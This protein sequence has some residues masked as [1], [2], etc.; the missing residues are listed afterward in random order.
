MTSINE[1]AVKF[2]RVSSDSQ[3]EANQVAAVDKHFAARGYAEAREPFKLHD[4]SASKGE[5]EKELAEILADVKAGKYTVV[6]I[7]NSARIDRRDPDL[8]EFWSLSVR[9]AGGR[10]ESASEPEFGKS[11][12]SGKMVT[13]LAQQANYDYTRTLST[14]VRN[15]FNRIDA[16]GGI[17]NAAGYGHRIV[18]EKY[19]K[20]FVLDEAEADV[21]R[22]VISRYLSGQGLEHI[23]RWLTSEGHRGRNGAKW[24]PRTLG[25]LLRNERLIGRFHQGD[26]VTRVPSITTVKNYQATLARLDAKAYRK[27]ARTRDDNALLTS[28]LFC[29]KCGRPMYAIKGGGTC[30]KKVWNADKT[31]KITRRYPARMT[32]NYYCRPKGGV[33]CKMMVDLGE[34]D[35]EVIENFGEEIVVAHR[36]EEVVIPGHDYADDIEQVV[37]D[38]KAL[39]PKDLGWLDRVTAMQAEIARLALLSPEEST[40]RTRDVDTVAEAN[41]WQQMPY[42]EKRQAMIDAGLKLYAIKD[43]SGNVV[44]AAARPATPAGFPAPL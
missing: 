25:H 9:L 39:D 43:A 34:T 38:I 18:G 32:L 17:R 30:T 27:G 12:L 35:Q 29:G 14:N 1:L 23:C 19:S 4:V 41:R 16:N 2:Y 7:A 24:T 26:T 3:D 20:H 33:S 37:L 22:L 13:L 8:Q 42:A 44:L 40:T 5:H 21:I 36:T 31:A 28:I 15:S 11:T 6:V 10:I